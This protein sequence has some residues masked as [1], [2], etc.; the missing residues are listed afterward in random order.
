MAKKIK[1]IRIYNTIEWLIFCVGVIMS[2]LLVGAA[3]IFYT[4][5]A[6][7]V[8]ALSLA[9]AAHAIGGRA[10]GIG[11][12]IMNGF[13]YVWTIG[14]NFYLEVLI[15]CFTYSISILSINNYIKFRVI[16]FYAIQLERKAR[17]HKA[18]IEKYGWLGLFL[19][20]MAPLPVTGP[21]VGSIIGSLLKFKI[22]KNFSATLLGTLAAIVIWTTF[23]DYLELHLNAIRYILAAIIAVVLI[24]YARNIKNFF[25][26]K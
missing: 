10:A 14:Y 24:S 7:M 2:L 1:C 11:L 18:K 13:N 8:H 6:K 23:F 4:S 25:S 3:W 17:N 9:F 16:R 20:V 12:C 22:A 15:V 19:F 21:V 26:K 5:D